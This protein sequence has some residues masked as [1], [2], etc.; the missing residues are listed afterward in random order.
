[1]QRTDSHNVNFLKS[2]DWAQEIKNWQTFL[3][4]KNIKN[5]LKYV[6][7]SSQNLFFTKAG[8]SILLLLT[9]I[10]VRSIHHGDDIYQTPQR[11]VDHVTFVCVAH[12][13][14]HP[15]VLLSLRFDKYNLLGP[16]NPNRLQQHHSQSYITFTVHTMPPR[17][18]Q[19]YCMILHGYV[20]DLVL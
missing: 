2:Y 17:A 18:N 20:W 10:I 3:G 9:P 1:M 6:F 7:F 13:A 5:P 8:A 19:W 11:I 14:P 15:T 12:A 16:V 4:T